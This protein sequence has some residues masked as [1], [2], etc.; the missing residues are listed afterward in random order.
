MPVHVG[1]EGVGAAG[2]FPLLFGGEGVELSRLARQPVAV[3]EGVVPADVHHG[4]VVGDGKAAV[5]AK[6]PVRGVEDFVLGVGDFRGAHP[7]GSA[8]VWNLHH[9]GE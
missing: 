9:C 5:S 8:G 2:E 3:G 7:E 4:L 1:G 6:C